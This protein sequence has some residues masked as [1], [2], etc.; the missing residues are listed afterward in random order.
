MATIDVA[1]LA[2]GGPA[3][4]ADVERFIMSMTGA[5]PTP[6]VLAAVVRR[7]EAIGGGSPL[8]AITARQAAALQDAMVAELGVGVRVRPGYLYSSPTVAE[9]LAELDGRDTVV[10]PMSPYSS[11]L[12]TG[13]YHA[14]LAVAGHDDLSFVDDWYAD[15][16]YLAALSQR[17]NETLDGADPNEFALLFTAHNVPL[18]TVAEGDPY[19]E[20]L[21]QTVAQL[22]PALMPGDWRLAFQSKGRRGGEWLEPEAATAVRELAAAGWD[23]LL[24]VPIGF[25]ADHVETLYD[26]DI[27]LREVV[28]SCDMD[29]L[30]CP[31][32]NDAPHF[33][34]AL[35]DIVI[36]H[37]AHRPLRG[38]VDLGRGGPFGSGDPFGSGG[39]SGPG[40]PFGPGDPLR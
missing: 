31:A 27:E 23:K 9:C 35:A 24:V 3:S 28:E 13:A 17:I 10:L 12:T 2:F 29:Y 5:P 18:E 40:D 25:V 21:H 11:R 19:V 32:L 20:Q 7:Y 22:L 26:L 38:P 33:I 15:R 8:P 39:S 37:L 34:A 1:M 16:R 4:V 36:D 6:E 14:A 30:R